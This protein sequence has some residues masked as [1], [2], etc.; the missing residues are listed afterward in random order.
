M[1][2]SRFHQEIP[3]ESRRAIETW[4]A[5]FDAV[6]ARRAEELIRIRRHLHAHPEPSGE[7]TATSDFI[8]QK[9]EQSGI[10]STRCAAGVGVIAELAVGNPQADS[11]LI[12]LRADIDGLRMPDE[13]QVVYCSQIPGVAH[14]CGH[15]AHTAALLGV[16]LAAAELN[17]GSPTE[18]AVPGVRLRLIFQ[19]AEETSTGARELVAQGAVEGVSTILALHV[20]P[21]R[22]C[23]KVGIRYGMLT[24]HCD[25]IEMV[26]TG[27]GG[28]AARPHHAIDP[29]AAAAH[30][31]TAIY[32]YLPRSVDSR[33]PSVVTIGHVAGGS[34]SNVIPDRV[35]LH[36]TLRTIDTGARQTLKNR[37]REICGGVEQSSGTRIAVGFHKP[38]EGVNNDRRA[39]AALEDASREVLGREGVA[40]IDRPSMGG[41]DF[42][43]YL[44]QVPGA[45]LRLGCASPGEE[46]PFLH[47]PLFDIDEQ[48][49]ALGTR[50]L[51]RAA[52]LSAVAASAGQ[53]SS[54]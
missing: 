33:D 52:L 9:L 13:K 43:V 45:M 30:L 8:Q 28:H 54:G 5:A 20:D 12:A 37:I 36:G 10:S 18:T 48:A 38:L 47:S 32:E 41:E 2:Q 44:T 17:S 50:I 1:Y 19:P 26:V 40:H 51:F 21:Q 49:I 53:R 4:G 15:D 16:G 23:G 14:A 34:A 46:A 22:A 3:V 6:V 11:P 24:A 35:E 7:E 31:I 25:E 29:I 42:S 27:G 39:A